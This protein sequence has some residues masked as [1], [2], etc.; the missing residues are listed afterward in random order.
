M[1]FL[2]GHISKYNLKLKKIPEGQ[3]S[4]DYDGKKQ[5]ENTNY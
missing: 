3:I 1:R 2:K 5:F 4:K